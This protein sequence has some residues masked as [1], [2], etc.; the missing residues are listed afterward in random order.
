MGLL[1]ECNQI[2]PKMSESCA[3][4]LKMSRM[5]QTV[6]ELSKEYCQLPVPAIYSLDELCGGTMYTKRVYIHVPIGS[7]TLTKDGEY[8]IIGYIVIDAYVHDPFRY[9]SET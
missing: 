2:I 3:L 4:S 9:M 5:F 7:L 6:T 1:T 8:I